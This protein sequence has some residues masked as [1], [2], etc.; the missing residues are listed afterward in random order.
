VLGRKTDSL[1]CNLCRRIYA[2]KLGR[3]LSHLGY[4]ELPGK[5]NSGVGLCTKLTS[6][7]LSLFKNCGG[8]YPRH[9]GELFSEHCTTSTLKNVSISEHSTPKSTGGDS[10]VG[11]TQVP[12]VILPTTMVEPTPTFSPV[13]EHESIGG[14]FPR[15]MRQS[16]ISEGFHEVERRE[17]DKV[18][19]KF[20]YEANV[21]FAVARNIAF[22]E[23]VMKTATFKRPY[24]PP[25]YHD[26]RTRLL[27]QA[28]ADLEA[29]LNTR[30]AESVRKFGGTLT[31]DGWTSVTNRPLCNAMLV[32]PAGE[33]FL[34][35]VDT[36]GSEKTA[37]YMASI[38]EKFI[39]QV[40][41]HNIVQICTDNASSMLKASQIIIKKYPHIYVQGCAAHAMDL[42]LEDWGKTTWIK[43]T[44]HKAKYLV[45]FVKNRQMP[46]AVFRKH[47]VNLSLLLPGQ[48]RFASNFIMIDRLL[49][50]KEALEQSVVD[51]DWQAYVTKLRDTRKDRARTL[52]RTVKRLVLDEHFWERC[53]NFREMVAP[54][55]YALREFDAKEPCMGKVLHI[56]R[57]LE[58]HV[59]ALRT[60][61]F[62]LDSDLADVAE[63]E[64]HARKRM[65]TTDLHSAGALLN[66]YLLHDKELADDPDAI[67]A[68]KRV[69]QKLCTPDTYPDVV[70]EFIAFRHKNAPFHDMLD[71]KLQKCSPYAWWDF[72]GACG[73]FLAPIAKRILA[74]TLSSS[75]CE[76]NWSSYSFVH[77]KI[78]NRLLPGRANDLVYVY[79]NSKLLANG[80]LTDE[81][82]WYAENLDLEDPQVLESDNSEY[83]HN[84]STSVHANY[85][86]EHLDDDI[87]SGPQLGTTNIH[88]ASINEYDF[89]DDDVVGE[90]VDGLLPIARFVN[91]DGMVNSNI[92]LGTGTTPT[93]EQTQDIIA[94]EGYDVK[95]KGED[96]VSSSRAKALHGSETQ[97]LPVEN[98]LECNMH[99]HELASNLKQ[100]TKVTSLDDNV[101]LEGKTLEDGDKAHIA[102]P[103]HSIEKKTSFSKEQPSLHG[104]AS[105]SLFGTSPRKVTTTNLKSS[106]GLVSLSKQ[107]RPRSPQ[108]QSD[109]FSSD[110][111]LPLCKVFVHHSGI[112]P[113]HIL[114]SSKA[115]VLQKPKLETTEVNVGNTSRP[116]PLANATKKRKSPMHP[117]ASTP[118]RN[119]MQS[120]NPLDVIGTSKRFKIIQTITNKRRIKEEDTFNSGDDPSGSSGAEV[121][122]DSDYK[123]PT[124]INK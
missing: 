93:L 52:S 25:S 36:T 97:R 70:N 44:L 26:I 72:E 81:K 84:S 74:Q 115:K 73:K 34:G 59:L 67:T 96:D 91:G 16:V 23:A 122:G 63:D 82:R 33:L 43:E 53:T 41:P 47:E 58:K 32:S 68:C 7:V 42:L 3:Q 85:D 109:S 90:E 56:I 11:S 12:P 37:E 98:V 95:N 86:A 110:G 60:E 108:V 87:D 94:R 80:K 71:P 100:T 8:H 51:P 24:V 119:H 20:F 107:R 111:N 103:L 123:V 13:T 17:L 27:V 117:F 21:P 18:W 114:S 112:P 45:K 46:L 77:N 38:M 10:C 1:Q 99:D 19:A 113:R 120:R 54:V 106:H 121:K 65:I 66:P 2:R 83:S 29:Q 92:I 4:E 40:G 22:K 35:S 62:N 48:T 6:R 9:N 39:E 75:S 76:R 118:L 102:S 50:V 55:V 124:H 64:F 49:K 78:R 57:D 28:K 14:T 5:R 61:P 88:N 79:T 116:R 101:A 105:R 89:S 31:V 104:L 69:L 30:M 15:L